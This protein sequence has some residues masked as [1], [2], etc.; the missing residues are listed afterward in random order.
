MSY[1]SGGQARH[2]VVRSRMGEITD[3]IGDDP[4]FF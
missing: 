2:G 3:G 1:M 4:L